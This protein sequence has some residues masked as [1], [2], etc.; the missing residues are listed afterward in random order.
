VNVLTDA[1][2]VTPGEPN[3]GMAFGALNSCQETVIAGSVTNAL[4]GT[5]ILMPSS[6][7]V[8]PVK[9]FPAPKVT[10]WVLRGQLEFVQWI[11]VYSRVDSSN[12]FER[13]LRDN[14]RC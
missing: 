1:P 3:P 7:N 14:N 13:N 2:H 5:V 9:A 10:L 4:S 6:V 11:Q 12:H 8:P